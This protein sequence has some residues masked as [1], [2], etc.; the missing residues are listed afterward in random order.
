[1]LRQILQALRFAFD[2][3]FDVPWQGVAAMLVTV[4]LLCI[5]AYVRTVYT[6][7]SSWALKGILLMG[8][9]IA[10]SAAGNYLKRR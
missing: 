1:M 6:W 7:N 3:F 8:V 10:L 2:D 9:F 4:L 5:Y